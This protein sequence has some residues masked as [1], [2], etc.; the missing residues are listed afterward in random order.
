M[1]APGSLTWAVHVVIGMEE[2][3]EL[4]AELLNDL[5]LQGACADLL[6]SMLARCG[7]SSI[8]PA[9]N[10]LTIALVRLIGRTMSR[11]LHGTYWVLTGIHDRTR[12][13]ASWWTLGDGGKNSWT[14]AIWGR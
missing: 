7:H 3:Q 12:Y 6:A 5:T 1:L 8:T 11:E 13:L 10:A 9:L 2:L 4:Q 14:P